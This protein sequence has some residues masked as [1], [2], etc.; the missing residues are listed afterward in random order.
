MSQIRECVFQ[1]VHTS[2]HGSAISCVSQIN[3]NLFGCV[4]INCSCSFKGISS[5]RPTNESSGGACFFDINNLN[6]KSCYFYKCSGVGLGAAIYSAGPINKKCEVSCLSSFMCFNE[7]SSIHSVFAFE[8]FSSTITSINSSYDIQKS[9]YGVLTIGRFPK[10]YS[11]NYMNFIFNSIKGE[12]PNECVL[13]L[14]LNSNKEDGNTKHMFVGNAESQQ[15]LTAFWSGNHILSYCVFVQCKGRLFR[16]VNQ[17]P[18]INFID[19]NFDPNI[20]TSDVDMKNCLT[21]PTFSFFSLDCALP[22]LPILTCFIKA[23][24]HLIAHKHLFLFLGISSQ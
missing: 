2:D 5:A 4:F 12:M 7:Q 20:I 14:S 23:K 24:S 22:H 21:S 17:E 3:Y 16:I 15:G 13:G 9:N 8:L 19:C 18:T 11:L 1:D 10:G 6:A